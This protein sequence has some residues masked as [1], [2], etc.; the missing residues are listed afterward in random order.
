MPQGPIEC[1]QFNC[2]RRNKISFNFYISL[3]VMWVVT[4]KAYINTEKW[5]WNAHDVN[6]H[7]AKTPSKITIETQRQSDT[8]RL[9]TEKSQ[10]QR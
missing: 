7:D 2:K 4:N 5:T 8:Y 1:D 3:H 9:E 10:R 6:A